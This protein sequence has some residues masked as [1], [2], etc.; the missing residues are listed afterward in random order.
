[1]SFE[2]QFAL[3]PAKNALLLQYARNG[4]N[5]HLSPER[6]LVPEPS[7]TLLAGLLSSLFLF[8]RKR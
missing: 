6:G 7:S 3:D 8:R 2:M 1:M 4:L 5:F